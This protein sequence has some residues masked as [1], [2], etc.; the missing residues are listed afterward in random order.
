MDNQVRDLLVLLDFALCQLHLNFQAS[1]IALFLMFRAMF[2][3]KHEITLEEWL[4]LFQPKEVSGNSKAFHT[5]SVRLESNKIVQG[6]LD[7]IK[8]W[9]PCFF[10]FSSIG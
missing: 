10:Y 1:I 9:K 5:C 2:E 4:H 6:P 7:S 8:D 3:G